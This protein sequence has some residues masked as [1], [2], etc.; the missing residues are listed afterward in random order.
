[1]SSLDKEKLNKKISLLTWSLVN[2]QNLSK[3]WE[4]LYVHSSPIYKSIHKIGFDC[5]VQLLNIIKSTPIAFL[6]ES[7]KQAQGSS[8][9]GFFLFLPHERTMPT[10]GPYLYYRLKEKFLGK[11][12]ASKSKTKQYRK[13]IWLNFQQ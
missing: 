6:P 13:E 2:L 9:L 5:L 12:K 3:H 8:P 10:Q 1:M 4:V 7:L 11:Q